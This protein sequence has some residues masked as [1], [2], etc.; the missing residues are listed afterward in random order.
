MCVQKRWRLLPDA[1]MNTEHAGFRKNRSCDY[2]I[3]CLTQLISY[4]Y[5][6]TKPKKTVLTLLDYSK[7]FSHVWRED[8]LNRAIVTD[9]SIAYA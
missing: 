9:L 2:Q 6:A 5:Q 3:L 8:L 1:N 4:R 7:V